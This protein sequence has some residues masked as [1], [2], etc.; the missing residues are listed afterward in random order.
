MGLRLVAARRDD[1]VLRDMSQDASTAPALIALRCVY[2]V[3]DPSGE[4]AFC[5]V[6][7]VALPV[8]QP[9][10]LDDD[11]VYEFAAADL[12]ADLQRRATGRGWSMRVELEL[13]QTAADATRCDL[14]A[15]GP[16]EATTLQLL[17][18]AEGPGGGRRLTLGTGLAPTP[19]AVVRLAGPYTVQHAA[20]P[21][22]VIEPALACTFKL[23]LTEYEFEA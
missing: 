6:Y 8:A 10:A 1:G 3:A 17:A 18:C 15:Q 11:D 21:P 19:E 2:G 14:Y 7:A 4:A 12:L 22:S 20:A 23:G 9:G 5:P 16:E 13:E